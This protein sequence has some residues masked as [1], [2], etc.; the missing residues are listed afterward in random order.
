MTDL[1]IHY[2]E[3]KASSTLDFINWTA[4][5][6]APFVF[7]CG[8]SA[9]GKSTALEAIQRMHEKGELFPKASAIPEH[10][11]LKIVNMAAR[12]VRE[13]LNSPSWEDLI[14][15]P[16]LMFQ[17][18]MFIAR[19]YF[20]VIY[21]QMVNR[22]AQAVIH[23]FERCPLDVIGYTYAFA[24][25]HCRRHEDKAEV[26][27]L[28]GIVHAQVML[29]WHQLIEALKQKVFVTYHPIDIRMGYAINEHRPPEVI[30]DGTS[31]MLEKLLSSDAEW[32][33]IC[34]AV[35]IYRM[36]SLDTAEYYKFILDSIIS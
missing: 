19:H 18:Q 6:R 28:A 7:M 17:H 1:N 24:E 3:K 14:E 15:D 29:Q 13:L 26:L 25:E 31:N 22:D 9:V 27:N 35:T 33:K 32:V 16:Q 4:D 20:R 10:R 30:R 11:E 2:L 5:T 8:S 21:E 12:T 36:P 34:S 23:L